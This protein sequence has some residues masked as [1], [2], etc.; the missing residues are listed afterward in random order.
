MKHFLLTILAVVTFNVN[1]ATII[2]GTD[3]YLDSVFLNYGQYHRDTTTNLEWLNFSDLVTTG[4]EEIT[5]KN[6]INSAEAHYGP[7]GWRLAT[8]T[9]LTGLF[10][11]FFPTYDSGGTGSMAL[12]DFA[13]PQSPLIAARNSWMF[14]FGTDVRPIDGTDVN[15]GDA[16]LYSYGLYVDDANAVQYLG[17]NIKT[18]PNAD[19]TSALFGLD[20]NTGDLG[21]DTWF[22][23]AG[24]FMVREYTVV[25][26]PAAVWLFG[27]GLLGLVAVA[28]R[29]V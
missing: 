14:A 1:A 26:I 2:E 28:W 13:D 24:V 25:P 22:E 3:P 21:R 15:A 19:L 10:N 9:E 4:V 5:L 16:D 8:E 12:D 11:L 7:Q 29:K 20:N 23:N 6:S 18:S 27:A 17:A